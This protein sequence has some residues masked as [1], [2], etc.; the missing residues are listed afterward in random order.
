LRQIHQGRVAETSLYRRPESEPI[1][2]IDEVLSE[3]NADF[4][5]QFWVET[6]LNQMLMTFETEIE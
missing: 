2:E 3:A 6:G 1:V 5:L 4:I